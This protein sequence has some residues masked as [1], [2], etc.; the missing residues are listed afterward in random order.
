MFGCES[1]KRTGVLEEHK[2]LNTCFTLD[3]MHERSVLGVRYVT[4]ESE[5]ACF[6]SGEVCSH[7]QRSIR[8]RCLP[9]VARRLSHPVQHEVK[10]TATA[11]LRMHS[12][13]LVKGRNY[14]GRA[15]WEGVGS[16]AWMMLFSNDNSTVH[17]LAE[18]FSMNSMRSMSVTFCLR[19]V[20]HCAVGGLT[21]NGQ[22]GEARLQDLSVTFEYEHSDAL[23]VYTMNLFVGES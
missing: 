1:L 12:S 15:P 14:G 4:V 20:N 2:I 9:A 3:C 6:G 21:R 10:D 23:L 18:K 5:T 19:C 17:R 11:K 16:H 22:R 8:R 13:G 7:L